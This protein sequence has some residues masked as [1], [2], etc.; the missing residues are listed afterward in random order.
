MMARLRKQDLR[1][2]DMVES[3]SGGA[4]KLSTVVSADDRHRGLVVRTGSE[5][6]RQVELAEVRRVQRV[7]DD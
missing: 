6:P 5:P 3:I 7:W 4:W 2:G 1:P